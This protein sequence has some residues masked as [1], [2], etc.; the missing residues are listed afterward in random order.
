MNINIKLLKLKICMNLNK[1]I[2][3]DA[4]AVYTS[5]LFSKALNECVE[6]I[7]HTHT[8]IHLY[9]MHLF[10]NYSPIMVM[11]MSRPNTMDMTIIFTIATVGSRVLKPSP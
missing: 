6:V 4:L 9:Y 2:L 5:Q 7:N 8:L 1:F 10:A 11:K 3:S